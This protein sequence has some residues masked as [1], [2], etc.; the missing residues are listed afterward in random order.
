MSTISKFLQTISISFVE[1]DSS[2]KEWLCW[3]EVVHNIMILI[4]LQS[5][6]C[7][8]LYSGDLDGIDEVDPVDNL[9]T[10]GGGQ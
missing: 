2:P 8:E 9:H 10:A 4:I 7:S 5:P 1:G 6:E 3:S